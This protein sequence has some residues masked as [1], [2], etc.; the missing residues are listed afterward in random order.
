MGGQRQWSVTADGN[1][2]LMITIQAAKH[3]PDN[4]YVNVLRAE[5]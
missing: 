4:N 2:I 5:L 3:L 1:K